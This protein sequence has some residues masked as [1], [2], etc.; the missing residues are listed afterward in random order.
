[1]GLPKQVEQVILLFVS[2]V[3]QNYAVGEVC[4]YLGLSVYGADA[5]ATVDVP[6]ADAAITS[7][8]SRCQDVWLP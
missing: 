8:A 4:G 2:P 6:D 1:M 7:A 5:G 3:E